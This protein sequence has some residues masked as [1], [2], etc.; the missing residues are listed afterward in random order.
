[1]VADTSVSFVWSKILLPLTCKCRSRGNQRAATPRQRLKKCKIKFLLDKY[2][3]LGQCQK[4][5]FKE[6]KAAPKK[7][8][9]PLGFGFGHWP[10]AQR[11]AQDYTWRWLVCPK[12]RHP[13]IPNHCLALPLPWLHPISL[14]FNCEALREALMEGEDSSEKCRIKTADPPL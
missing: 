10:K 11:L 14:L 7:G 8:K 13:T 1:M 5:V 3:A 6:T 12:G 9:E 2:T 4:E